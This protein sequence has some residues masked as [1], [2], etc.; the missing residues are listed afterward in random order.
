MEQNLP[1]DPVMLLSF[2][3]TQLR[4]HFATLTEFCRTY[5]VAEE[6]L[7]EKLSGIDYRYDT[8]KNQFR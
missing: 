8:E 2:V 5:D 6:A 7:I 1:N 3:N 4:D